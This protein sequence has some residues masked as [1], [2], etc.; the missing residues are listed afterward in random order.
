MKNLG[1]LREVPKPHRDIRELGA[2]MPNELALSYLTALFSEAVSRPPKAGRQEAG[3][4]LDL[5][6]MDDHWL[7]D[8]HLISVVD[9]EAIAACDEHA[10]LIV[11]IGEYAYSPTGIVGCIAVYEWACRAAE[12]IKRRKYFGHPTN[13]KWHRFPRPKHL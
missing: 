10:N 4:R 13:G 7:Q 5:Q 9:N 2:S 1:G 11:C 12:L 8:V 6:Q 3:M